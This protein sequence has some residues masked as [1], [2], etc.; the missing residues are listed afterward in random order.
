MELILTLI[1]L[2]F[3]LSALAGLARLIFGLFGWRG[4]L[5]LLLGISITG[6]DEDE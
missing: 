2:A 5:G 1:V 4:I 6:C 3:I